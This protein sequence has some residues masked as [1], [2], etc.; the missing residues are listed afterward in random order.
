MGLDH[1]FRK[2]V[3]EAYDQPNMSNADALRFLVT[4]GATQWHYT[5][6][7]RDRD[8]ISPDNWHVTQRLLDRPGNEA[9]QLQL[10]YDYGSNPPLYPSWQDTSGLD[11][12][13]HRASGLSERTER[14][15]PPCLT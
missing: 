1:D 6:G 12:S 15:E 10:F 5:N 3:K 9:I 2:N 4:L 8:V 7:V 13:D 14:I 11:Q